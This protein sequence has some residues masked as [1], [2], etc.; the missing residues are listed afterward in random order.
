[1]LV[2]EAAL[3]H[4]IGEVVGREAVEHPALAARMVHGILTPEQADWIRGHHERI[5]G[6]GYPDGRAGDDIPAEARIL[7]VADAWDALVSG[8]PDDPALDRAQALAAIRDGA[9]T[10]YCEEV[11]AALLRLEAAG[12]LEA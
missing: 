9:G 3:V 6:T 2:R 12:A 4:D 10:R 11:V 8:R 7:A 1:V 5:D